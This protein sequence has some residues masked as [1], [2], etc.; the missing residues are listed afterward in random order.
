MNWRQLNAQINDMSEDELAAM[1]DDELNGMR[2]VTLA[3]RLHQRLCT[4]RAERE[5]TAILRELNHD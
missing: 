3:I 5:R 2:R 1:L 4:L